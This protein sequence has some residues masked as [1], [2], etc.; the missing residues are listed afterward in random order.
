ML[1]KIIGYVRKDNR[2]YESTK[3]K[4][5]KVIRKILLKVKAEY[6][7]NDVVLLIPNYKSYSGLILGIISK[8]IRR[9]IDRIGVNEL[10]FEENLDFVKDKFNMYCKSNGKIIMKKSLIKIFEYIFR[11]N[12]V[13]INLENVYIL[14]NEYN[15]QNTY[16]INEL[17]EKFKTVNI[18]TENIERYKRMENYWYSK[19]VLITV[20]NNRRKSLRNAKYIINI[21]FDK[22][23]ILM[24]N[25]NSNS[26]IINLVDEFISIKSNFNGVLINNIELKID[27]NKECFINEFYG[28]INKKIFLETI[29]KK[30]DKRLEYINEINQEY[31]VKI[32]GLI[33]VRGILENNEFLV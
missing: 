4:I 32:S 33:G 13:N 25:I 18:I 1:E 10:V 7:D 9:K 28:N 8:Q 12:N 17:I 5:Y 2:Q 21:D 30:N 6:I 16:I 22:N 29:I 27:S 20:S 19:G 14:V 24:Y 23:K 11:L 26:I 15:K 31:N 3:E